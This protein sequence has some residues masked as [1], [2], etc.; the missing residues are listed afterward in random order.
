[1]DLLDPK[2]QFEELKTSV[3]KSAR[4]LFPVE[5]RGGKKLVLD[6]VW[7]EDNLDTED[8]DS[9]YTAKTK[10]RT[11]AVPVY[12]KVRLENK[13]GKTVDTVEKKRLFAIPKITQRYSY[14][15]DGN[16]YQFL[17]QFRLKSGVYTRV[18][19]NGQIAA[20]FNLAK[21]LEGRG[22]EIGLD[23]DTGVFHFDYRNSKIPLYGVAKASG[24]S[25]D[26][27]ESAHARLRDQVTR[28]KDVLVAWPVHLEW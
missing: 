2:Q 14:I 11:W 19:E 5:S 18:K 6:K 20:Q 26:D 3:V 22:F 17:N 15:L 9:Q 4:S 7:V 28:L 10:G 25:D 8:L 16:E 27:L 12:A 21:Q 24:I 1:M 23:P 13:D